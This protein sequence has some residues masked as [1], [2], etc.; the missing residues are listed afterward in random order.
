MS[1][2]RWAGSEVVSGS[3]WTGSR[4]EARPRRRRKVRQ[5]TWLG[6]SER[7]EVWSVEGELYAGSKRVAKMLVVVLGVDGG[8]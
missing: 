2:V 4:S 5:S 7:D 8:S 1:V 3:R 6:S